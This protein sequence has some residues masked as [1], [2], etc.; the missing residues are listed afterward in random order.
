AHRS[1]PERR[2]APADD[3]AAA[4]RD[5]AAR[6]ADRDGDRVRLPQR[7]RRRH[8]RRRPRAGRRLRGDDRPRLRQHRPGGARRAAHA[9][10]GRPARAEDAVPRRRPALRLVRGLRR[11]GGA[12]RVPLR[13]GGRLRRGQARGRR[14]D[15]GRPRPGD[16]ARRHPGHGPRRPDPAD[17]DGARRLPRP[18]AQ[19]RGGQARPR[20]GR[21]AAGGGLLQH[22]LRGDPVG[23][24]RDDHAG[25]AGPGDRHRRRPVDRRPGARVPR[26]AGYPRGSRREVRQALRGP[27]RRD[28][29]GR[30]RLR[31]R[32]ARAPV[33]GARARVHDAARGARA[34][35]QL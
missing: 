23:R 9:C 1:D 29:R 30:R 18:G 32:R 12:D 33:P 26:P 5:E 11:A 2:V 19:R 15:L 10:Q 24:G 17:R 4:H 22:R 6:R 3:A 8:R 31:G 16:H 7:A 21:R 27:A 13:Q 25:H 20:R 28:G 14:H 34:L 35:P